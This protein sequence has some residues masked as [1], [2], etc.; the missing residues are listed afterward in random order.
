MMMM[1]IT[2]YENNFFLGN[3]NSSLIPCANSRDNNDDDDDYL[4]IDIDVNK[5]VSRG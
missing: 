1:M 5:K 2:S 3:L 4:D